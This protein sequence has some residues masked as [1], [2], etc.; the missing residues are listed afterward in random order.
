MKERF[1]IKKV[2][3]WLPGVLISIL[4][5]TLIGK[6][7]D[8]N[9]FTNSIAEFDIKDILVII[10]I[11]LISLAARAVIWMK[12]LPK[13]QFIDSF[14]I[15]N[16]SYLFNN[17]IPRSGEIIKTI[18]FAQPASENAIKIFS[19]VIVER[20]FDLVIA[21]TMFLAT[22]PFV[23]QLNSLRPIALT[24]LMLFLFTLIAG[25]LIAIKAQKV[26]NWLMKIGERDSNFK[27]KILPRIELFIDGFQILTNWKQIFSVLFWIIISWLLW[28]SIIFYTVNTIFQGVRFWWAIFIQGVLALG[29]ALP[30]APAGLGV[31]EGTVVA[32]LSVFDISAEKALAIAVVIHL[33]QIVVTTIIGLIA[34]MK[35]GES[36]SDIFRK[37]RSERQR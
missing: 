4:I 32:S 7:V 33:F 16:E 24:L 8:L 11:T 27:E 5:I 34:V 3:R 19:C 6:V 20:S 17:L 21:A 12:L 1:G 37:I 35:Q 31:F 29:I 25:L 2:L 30:S 22:F 13:V 15:I 10:A 14:L 28:T 36:I 26:K 9:V 18:L 23:S